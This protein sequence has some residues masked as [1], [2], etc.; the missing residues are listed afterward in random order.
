[1]TPEIISNLEEIQSQLET[2]KANI[3]GIISD[4][5]LNEDVAS[6]LESE[7]LDPIFNSIYSLE[8]FLE[9]FNNLD[10]EEFYNDLD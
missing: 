6:D 10:S 8:S 2:I 5:S 1:M 9:D 3:E 4:P 7:L